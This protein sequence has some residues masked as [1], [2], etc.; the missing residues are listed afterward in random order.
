MDM[1]TGTT[2]LKDNLALCI[3]IFNIPIFDHAI[4]LTKIQLEV[5]G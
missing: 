4:L 2:S 3:K 5:T 1:Q